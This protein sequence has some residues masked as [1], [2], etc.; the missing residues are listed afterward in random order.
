M[1]DLPRRVE[2]LLAG[3]VACAFMLLVEENRLSPEDAAAPPLAWELAAEAVET[4][5]PWAPR[6]QTAL[7]ETLVTRASRL[8]WMAEALAASPATSWWWQALDRSAQHMPMWNPAASPG[9]DA[10]PPLRIP[11]TPASP[12]ERYAQQAETARWTSTVIGGRSSLATAIAREV[13]DLGFLRWDRLVPVTAPQ[14]AR[15]A[16]I[17]GPDDWHRLCVEH[18]AESGPNTPPHA[19]GLVPDWSLIAAQHDGVHLSFGG[20]LTTLWRTITSD[21]GATTLWAWDSESTQWL[22]DVLIEGPPIPFSEDDHIGPYLVG[23][24]EP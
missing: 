8:R 14:D 3:P 6:D 2:A 18:P 10:I 4:T 11:A 17:H 16:E 21:A 1:V 13:G 24:R 22:R 12:W 15:L 20:L 5:S 9:P 23:L 7:F 19:V